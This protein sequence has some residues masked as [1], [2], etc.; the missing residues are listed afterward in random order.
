MDLMYSHYFPH[1]FLSRPNDSCL[2]THPFHQPWPAPSPHLTQRAFL[3]E[4]IPTSTTG[5]LHME[6]SFPAPSLRNTNIAIMRAWCLLC[7]CQNFYFYF[8]NKKGNTLC[9]LYPI[10]HS[11]FV[12]MYMI[13]SLVP[14]PSHHPVFDCMH[15]GNNVGGGGAGLVHFIT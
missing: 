6:S 10:I 4:S 7:G 11:I 5:T 2:G 8:L 9:I 14:R 1:C 15:Y 12:Y 13:F 3:A